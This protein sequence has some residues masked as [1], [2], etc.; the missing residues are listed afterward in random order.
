MAEAADTTIAAG[1]DDGLDAAAGAADAQGAAQGGTVADQGQTGTGE[2]ASASGETAADA[3]KAG[4]AHW[5]VAAANGNEKLAADMRRYKTQQAYIEA[6]FAARQRI[7]SGDVKAATPFPADGT[8]EQQKAWRAE[9]G[10]PAEPAGYLENLDGLVIGDADRP[11]I[12]AFAERMHGLNA[13][14]GVVKEALGW[15]YDHVGQQE[16]AQAEADQQFKVNTLVDLQKEMGP[17]FKGNMQAL[18]QALTVGILDTDGNVAIPAP[19]GLFATLMTART[20]DGKVIGN[21][22]DVLRFFSAL[23]TYLNPSATITP[24]SG[25]P[26]GK[27]LADEIAGIEA[28]MSDRQ[29]EYYKG[30][31]SE[32]IQARYRTLIEARERLSKKTAA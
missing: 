13:P 23:G 18:S 2:A 31:K 5:S 32:G 27:G 16:A 8:P 12:D 9:Q 1:A 21:H 3:G 4:D 19:D 6:G 29:S 28:M 15:Y 26:G 10:L 17:D 20:A 22:P 11:I 7:R 30:P 14:P 25:S 24:A